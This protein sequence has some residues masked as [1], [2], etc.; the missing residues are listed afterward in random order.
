MFLSNFEVTPT[1]SLGEVV[2]FFDVG[3]FTFTCLNDPNEADTVA[4][5]TQVAAKKAGYTCKCLSNN[6][7]WWKGLSPQKNSLYQTSFKIE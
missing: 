4:N 1:L 7:D 5:C 2:T 3:Q 6:D